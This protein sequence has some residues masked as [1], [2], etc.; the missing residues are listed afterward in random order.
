MSRRVRRGSASSEKSDESTAG[1][2]DPRYSVSLEVGLAILC[3]FTPARPMLGIAEIAEELAMSPSRTHRYVVTLLAR[4]YLEQNASRKY[5][6]GLRVTDLGMAALNSTS[7]RARAHP[8][9]V[10]LR[11]RT[12]H[13]TSLG[14]LDGGDVLL[15]DCVHSFH[16]GSIGGDL[17]L[18]PGS[19]LPVYC[20]AMGKLLLANLPEPVQQELISATK[21]TRRGRNTITSKKR[22][23]WEL[24]ETKVADFAVCDQELATEVLEI[25]APVRDEDHAVLAAVSMVVHSSRTSLAE[26]VAFGPQ[27][28][29]TANRISAGPGHGHD[30]KSPAR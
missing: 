7:L 18:G 10:E 23:R 21:P 16:R 12:S 26:L 3:A 13:T 8:R 11:E 24:Q 6:L 17:G 14:V 30:D 28:L 22:L 2:R 5:Q 1:L 27:L 25:A 15:L 20:T 4:G 9:L 19:R 29:R